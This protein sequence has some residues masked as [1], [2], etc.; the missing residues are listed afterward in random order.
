M[1]D[2]PPPL[3]PEERTIGQVIAETIR[4]YG[5]DFWRALPLG[6]P[7]AVADQ[8]SVRSTSRRQMVVYWALTPLFVRATSGPAALFSRVGRP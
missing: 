5:S 2:L 4:A 7:V 6:V 3:P 8:L 1:R